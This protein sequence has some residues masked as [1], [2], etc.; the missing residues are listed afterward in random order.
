M[1]T[2]ATSLLRFSNGF[3]CCSRFHGLVTTLRLR[4]FESTATKQRHTYAVNA[5][6]DMACDGTAA[7]SVA[8]VDDVAGEVGVGQLPIKTTG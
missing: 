1:Q 3:T 8:V 6:N 2:C 4:F 5:R 7:L